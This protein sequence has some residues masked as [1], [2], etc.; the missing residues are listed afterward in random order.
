MNADGR[1]W[2]TSH[3]AEPCE[4]GS[5]WLPTHSAADAATKAEESHGLHGWKPEMMGLPHPPP[6][7][8]VVKIFAERDDVGR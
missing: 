6:V 8:S 4:T 7:T 5:P 1:R 2:K 3:A